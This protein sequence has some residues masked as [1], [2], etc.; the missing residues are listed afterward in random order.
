M[1]EN[2]PKICIIHEKIYSYMCKGRYTLQLG[3]Y[4]LGDHE[5]L[6]LNWKSNYCYSQD[7]KWFKVRNGIEE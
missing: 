5:K 3:I 2:P 4:L 6:I 1:I 7:S